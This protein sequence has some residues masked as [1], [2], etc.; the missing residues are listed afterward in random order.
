MGQVVS[1]VL[2]Y[3]Y[4]YWWVKRANWRRWADKTA[5]VFLIGFLVLLGI[6]VVLEYIGIGVLAHPFWMKLLFF[7]SIG[8][9]LYTKCR[10]LGAR[11]Q[12][13]SFVDTARA[14]TRLL[15]RPQGE[16]HE[17]QLMKKLVGLF[18]VTFQRDGWA[19]FGLR[20]NDTR[21]NAAL[22]EGGALRIHY[23]QPDG[24]GAHGPPLPIGGSGAGYSYENDCL[25][26]FPRKS[27]RHAI[28][29]FYDD[30]P[31]DGKE[32]FSI[33]P[34][35]FLPQGTRNYRSVLSVPIRAHGS[36]FA[37]SANIR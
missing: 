5:V 29:Q 7:A 6:E 22:V 15:S 9:M 19:W 17:E 4:I 16:E 25:V 12:Q 2:S 1:I 10:E 20:G 35:I 32:R 37:L 8:I 27:L 36:R 3:S 31:E 23:E 26:Y 30:D 24:Q 11:R 34:D 33:A 21:V 14:V 28:V 13:A 18:Q